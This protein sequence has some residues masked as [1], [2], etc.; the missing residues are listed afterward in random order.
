MGVKP[1]QNQKMQN[2]AMEFKA[3][4]KCKKTVNPKEQHENTVELKWYIN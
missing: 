2:R 1:G 4:Q 3:T